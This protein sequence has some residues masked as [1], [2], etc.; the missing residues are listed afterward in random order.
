[1]S[2]LRIFV[3]ILLI[4]KWIFFNKLVINFMIIS[5]VKII[6]I[7]YIRIFIRMWQFNKWILF[8]KILFFLNDEY[9][10]IKLSKDVKEI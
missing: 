8:L 9:I 1:M 5:C 6:E 4:C 2:Y 7:F 3:K 10:C